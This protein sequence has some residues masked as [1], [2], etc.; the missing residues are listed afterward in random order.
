LTTNRNF[1]FKGDAMDFLIWLMVG[2]L[3]G[4]ITSM[5]TNTQAEQGILL[6]VVIGAIGALLGGWLLA[7]MLGPSAMNAQ[8]EAPATSMSIFVSLAC[9]VALLAIFNL[10]K[11]S[12]PR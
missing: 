11:R 5:V 4:W 8:T 10:C 7:P 3:I 2:G 12:V 1:F 9:A 6:N